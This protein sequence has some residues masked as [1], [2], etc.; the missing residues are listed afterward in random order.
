MGYSNKMTANHVLLATDPCFCWSNALNLGQS[1][2]DY[3]SYFL[4]MITHLS[5]LSKGL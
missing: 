4:A 1:Y 5:I 2:L 3:P